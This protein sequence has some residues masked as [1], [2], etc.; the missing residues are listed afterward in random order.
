M[1]IDDTLLRI[2]EKPAAW[3]IW[4]AIVLGQRPA[5][6]AAI[7]LAAVS[8]VLAHNIRQFFTIFLP[9][10]LFGAF[11]ALVPVFVVFLVTNG[12]TRLLN[13]GLVGGGADQLALCFD[14]LIPGL[15]IGLPSLLRRRLTWTDAPPDVQALLPTWLAIFAAAATAGLVST[16][17]F[18]KGGQLANMR[19]TLVIAAITA[20]VF[21]VF[22]FYSLL[23][24]A[25]WQRGY[26]MVFFDP[27]Q[28]WEEQTY[29][30]AVIWQ[31]IPFREA[32]QWLRS[33]R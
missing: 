10:L 19:P 13:L 28:W 23:A 3:A 7:V 33:R 31:A 4:A 5:A 17:H 24:R 27:A 22:P 1:I 11:L 8:M 20:V 14:F 25:C 9:L 6:W 12:D 15:L 32:V 18:V 2:G 26:R 29:A 30:G 21:L 16:L